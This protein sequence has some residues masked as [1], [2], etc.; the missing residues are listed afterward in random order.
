MTVAVSQ[1]GESLVFPSTDLVRS[2]IKKE[3]ERRQRG[4]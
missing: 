2:H 3:F 1:S 4:I